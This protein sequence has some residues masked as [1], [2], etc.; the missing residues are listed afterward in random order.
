MTRRHRSGKEAG[1]QPAGYPGGA[2]YERN[3]ENRAEA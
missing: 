2:Q 3:D 1:R